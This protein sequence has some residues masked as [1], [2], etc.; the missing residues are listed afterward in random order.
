[1]TYS[2]R[3]HM[4]DVRAQLAQSDRQLRFAGVLTATRVAQA[5]KGAQERAM[6]AV[7]DRPTAYTLRSLFMRKATVVEPVAEVWFKDERAASR[8][9]IPAATYLAPQ[10]YGGARRVKRFERVLQLAGHMPNGYQCVPGGGCKRDA[11]GNPSRGQLIQILS[12]LRI[13]L[14]AGHTR[15]MPFEARGQI[16]AQRRAGGRYFVAKAGNKLSPGIYI[17][18]FMGRSILP[19][20][21]FKKATAYRL[22]Y[23]F[24]SI[25]HRAAH[26]ALPDA[27]RNAIA[28]V[29]ATAYR[30]R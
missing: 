4:G 22:R 28:R 8:Q 16:A 25:A 10:V 6:P 5:V 17:R 21:L 30:S 18:D 2:Y 26:D 29:R 7:L 13:T 24:T 9:A 20:F 1:M 14:T 11:S 3:L 12:Q 15:N 19:V 23:D 27:R